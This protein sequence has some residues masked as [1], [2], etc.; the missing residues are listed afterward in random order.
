MSPI[1]LLKQK[2]DTN[3]ELSGDESEGPGESTI[4]FDIK[5]D[6]WD[7]RQDVLLLGQARWDQSLQTTRVPLPMKQGGADNVIARPPLPNS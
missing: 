1:S 3:Q 6:N 4:S 7:H 2:D 5:D